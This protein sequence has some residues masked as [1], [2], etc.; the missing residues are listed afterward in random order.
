MLAPGE[1][2][3][4]RAPLAVLVFTAANLAVFGAELWLLSGEAGP[5]PLARFVETWGLV[6]RELLRGLARPDASLA[7]VW[8][9]PL[10]AL[11]IH[12]GLL[13]L[14]ANLA[15]LV[16]FGARLE[17]RLGP[18]RFSILYLAC[19]LI[20]AVVQV[21]SDPSAYA[22]TIGASGAV[23]GVL[24]AWAVTGPALRARWKE[25]G[26]PAVLLLLA[27]VALQLG[28]VLG[29]GEA[30][31]APVAWW[32]HLGGFAAGALLGPTLWLRPPAASRLRI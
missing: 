9:T 7:R 19:G 2:P 1:P 20:A 8:L 15:V 22:A 27:W 29:T 10:T 3:S 30:S 28:S 17:E 31:A 11:F 21:A 25:L 12:G 13:H 16:T 24:G 4:S 5:E 6:P 14:A 23:S 32:A 18:L 26:L